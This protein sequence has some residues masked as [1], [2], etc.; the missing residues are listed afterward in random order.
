MAQLRRALAWPA[1][2]L[3]QRRARAELAGLSERELSDILAAGR[4]LGPVAGAPLEE[5][6]EERAQR[7]RAIRAWYGKAA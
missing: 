2:A 3:E 4:D 6:P 7:V 1:K 5:A